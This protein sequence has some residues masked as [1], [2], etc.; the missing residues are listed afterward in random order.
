MLAFLLADC[1]A[2]LIGSWVI[3]VVHVHLVNQISGEVFILFGIMILKGSKEE[4]EESNLSPENVFLSGFLMIILSEW[5]DKTLDR[6]RIIRLGVQPWM[7]F[8]GVMAAL[9]VLSIVAYGVSSCKGKCA[10]IRTP[11]Y[12]ETLAGRKWP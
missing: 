6:F 11:F 3:N 9:T 1:S 5:E 7:V 4:Y 8:I 2:I 12:A 10:E